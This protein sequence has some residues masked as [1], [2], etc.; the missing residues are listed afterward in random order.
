MASGGLKL[1]G[2]FT[3]DS[4]FQLGNNTSDP[5]HEGIAGSATCTKGMYQINSII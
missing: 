4:V 3:S 2:I 1:T 5:S